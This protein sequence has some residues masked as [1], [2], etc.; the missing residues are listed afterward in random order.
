MGTLRSRLMFLNQGGVDGDDE[1]DQTAEAECS[2]QKGSAVKI[3]FVLKMPKLRNES[4]R[5]V[6]LS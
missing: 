1:I 3:S 5:H 6:S 2:L 4:C